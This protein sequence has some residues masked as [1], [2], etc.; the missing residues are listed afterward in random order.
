MNH[1]AS[2]GPVTSATDWL[3]ESLPLLSASRAA[4]NV[5]EE[6]LVRHV[7]QEREQADAERDDEVLPQREHTERGADR[8]P[9]EQHR[10]TD[11]GDDQ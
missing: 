3:A 11:V 7:E 1:D 10:S 6:C 8:N 9:A 5:R 2:P 4:G